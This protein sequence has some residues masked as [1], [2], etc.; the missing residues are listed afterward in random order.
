M[1]NK[2]ILY[3]QSGGPTP[4]INT[5]FYGV[6][7]EYQK[8]KD[9]FSH[10]YAAHYGVEGLIEGDLFDI[11]KEEDSQIELLKQTPGQILGSS[12]KKL[13]SFDDPLFQKI[14]NTIE[15]YN[16]GYILTN[17]GNDS[18]DTCKRLHDYFAKQK[19]DVKVLGIPKT[20]DN[21]LMITDHSLGYPSAARHIMDSA[22]M[23]K[24]DLMNYRK[25]KVLIMEIMGR[26]SGW[27]TASTA[28]LPKDVRPDYIYLPE[29][30]WDEEEFLKEIEKI[31][32]KQHYVLIALSEG[33]PLK[34]NNSIQMDS[35][36]HVS[37]DGSAYTAAKLISD[38]LSLS[39]RVIC[40]ST[41]Q[42]SDATKI[43][44]VDSFEAIEA[45]S[46]AVLSLLKGESGKMVAIHR[47]SSSP[48]QS[49]PILVS[50]EEVANYA[51]KIPAS[52]LKNHQEMSDEFVTY[53]SP[54][55][56]ETIPV[57]RENGNLLFARF[58]F[59]KPEIA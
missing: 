32:K 51:K 9:V 44:K 38:K 10:L 48:Y 34:A 27:L 16:I 21:D 54:L 37:Y 52:Y 15:K 59:Q 49:E 31:Y 25:G 47:L 26:D 3:F 39:T 57:I 17:G 33:A 28:L 45:S 14:L 19:I 41:L 6:I 20:V 8:H 24:L 18:M 53:L 23:A 56:Q 2:A 40:D 43:T 50:L 11:D 30:E 42:R 1:Q 36:G 7:R 12:R 22:T 29:M 5:S 55:V 46:F 35:F 58:H 4:V 13:P